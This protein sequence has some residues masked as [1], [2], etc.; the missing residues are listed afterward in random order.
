MTSP[1]PEASSWSFFW[2]RNLK[3]V[4]VSKHCTPLTWATFR[5]ISVVT[6]VL[7]AVAFLGRVPARFLAPMT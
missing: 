2:A 1:S 3:P 7:R 6:M 5:A 4:K